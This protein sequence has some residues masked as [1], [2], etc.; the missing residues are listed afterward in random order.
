MENVRRGND[1]GIVGLAGIFRKLDR[2][3]VMGDVSSSEND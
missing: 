1:E 3:C 2:G